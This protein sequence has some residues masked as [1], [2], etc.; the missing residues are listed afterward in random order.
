MSEKKEVEEQQVEDRS[1]PTGRVIYKSIL[2]EGKT[3][4]ERPS[5]SLFWS[6]LASG[7]SMGFSMVGQG[8][9]DTYLPDAPWRP[10]VSSF[11]YSLGFL[12]VVLGRQQLFT[13]NTLTPVL[14]LLQRPTFG[15]LGEVLRLWAIVLVANLIGA[16]LFAL[17]VTHSPAFD[18]DVKQAFAE[19]GHKALEH[20]FGTTLIRG[21]FAGWLI[22]LMV[23]LL[24]LAETA[25]VWIIIILTYFVGLA[26]LSH[27]IAG[28]VETFT[29][30]AMGYASWGSVLGSFVAPALIGNM[31][32]GVM[33]VAVLNHAQIVAGG[34]GDDI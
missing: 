12:I 21:I 2:K 9:L 29:A 24:P 28:S 34:A 22:A 15:M 20:S 19:L 1:S 7:L 3:E 6:A 27:V 23:W 5:P 30:A 18:P 33:L 11:G 25:R 31:I 16:A 26:H 8:L 17:A 14:P 10:L 13:E 4:L 32:G